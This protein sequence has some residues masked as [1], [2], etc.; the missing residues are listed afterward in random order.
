[1]KGNA[2]LPAS[3]PRAY[4]QPM[5]AV[6]RVPGVSAAITR[7]RAAA[8]AVQSASLGRDAMAERTA[9]DVFCGCGGL[10]LGLK[11]AGFRVVGAVDI[12]RLALA[13]YELNHPG[14]ATW[15]MDVRDLDLE[16]IQGRL[17]LDR[18]QLDLLAGCPPCQ[19]F[20]TL[21]TLNGSREVSDDRNDLVFEF[22]RLVRELEPKAVMLENVPGLGT[23][24]RMTRFEA[25]LSEMG[26][27]HARR[28]LDTAD[29]G[30]P[31]KRRRLILLG[32]RRGTVD[33]ATPSPRRSSVRSAIESL[34][35]A[36]KS[37]DPL[38]DMPE[39]RTE[40]VRDL[41]R[42]IPKDGGGRL[43]LDGEDQLPCHRKF[44]GFKDVYG[45]MAWDSPA[46][47]IT[48]GCH[49]PSKGRFLHPTEDRAITLREAALLQGFPATY[50]FPAT[51]GKLAL[52]AMIGN[53]LPPAFVRS[54]AL[55]VAERL[56]A[57]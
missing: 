50:R 56:P 12:D 40:R 31:Q 38:H 47:T 36:G 19:G 14:A 11:Q 49:N 16:A 2:T 23:D 34:P 10:T 39:R 30:V 29:Y 33:F 25:A 21:R 43:D 32:S 17:G 27:S 26:Y 1:M 6:K 4:D 57:A 51:G 9:F 46:P 18:G 15:C 28:V 13:A 53:A 3:R 7:L 35:L 54:H 24:R 22:L 37:G 48:S 42:R 52:A 45:R 20:S 44:T 8:E 55:K 5:P 41:I